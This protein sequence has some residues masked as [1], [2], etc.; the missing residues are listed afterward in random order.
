[1]SSLI[2]DKECME[3]L[4]DL[5]DYKIKQKLT[6]EQRRMLMKKKNTEVKATAEGKGGR[7]VAKKSGR[8]KKNKKN[9]DTSDDEAMSSDEDTPMDQDQDEEELNEDADSKIAVDE[10][11]EDEEDHST[12]TTETSMREDSENYRELLKHIDDDG[13]KG[14]K[15]INVNFL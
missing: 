5:V 11:D 14:L 15:L 6:P 4:I 9:S 2:I 1:M 10:E 7:K 13:E 3:Y 12:K 8:P